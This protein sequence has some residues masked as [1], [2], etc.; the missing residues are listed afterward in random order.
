MKDIVIEEEHRKEKPN[1]LIDASANIVMKYKN[2]YSKGKTKVD[3]TEFIKPKGKIKKKKKVGICSVYG[4]TGYFRDD[5]PKKRI[6][7]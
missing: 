5:C 1:V 3:S 2:K 7:Y 4:Q 6:S